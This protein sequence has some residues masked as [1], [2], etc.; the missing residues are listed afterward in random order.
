MNQGLKEQLNANW[1]QAEQTKINPRY[2]TD[3]YQTFYQW[4]LYGQKSSEY[5]GETFWYDTAGYRTF[6]LITQMHI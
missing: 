4:F 5:H 2:A 6:D 3:H 1:A